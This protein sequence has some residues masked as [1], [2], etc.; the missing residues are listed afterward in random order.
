MMSK[1]EIFRETLRRAVMLQDA[2]IAGTP[3]VVKQLANRIAVD[4][5]ALLAMVD[6][7]EIPDTPQLV[8][9]RLRDMRALAL[10]VGNSPVH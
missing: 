2:G 6:E 5:R 3:T 10:L 4:M 1:E 8:E 9:Q 7:K